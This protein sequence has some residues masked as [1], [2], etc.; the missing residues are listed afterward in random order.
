MNETLK[1]DV[2]NLK[3]RKAIIDKLKKNDIH[4]IL[5]L[6]NNSRMDLSEKDFIKEEVNEIII[7]LQ[8]LGLDLKKNHAKKNTIIEDIVQS[9]K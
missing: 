7:T 2:K 3:I 9:K 8:L 1:K 4:T 6:C 5:E